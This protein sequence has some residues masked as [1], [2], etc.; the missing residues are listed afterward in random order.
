MLDDLKIL[1][2]LSLNDE[3][4]DELLEL[5]I[6]Q[7]TN[8]AKMITGAKETTPSLKVVIVKMAL[9][10]YNRMGTEG[11]KSES[12]SGASY[13]YMEGYPDDIMRLLDEIKDSC[14]GRVRFLW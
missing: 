3:S 6:K 5:L 2:G 1:L 8:E 13:S 12:Y 11:L 4:Q 10:N 14:K 7:A 9:Y